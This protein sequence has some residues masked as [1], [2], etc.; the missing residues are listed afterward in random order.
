MATT[1]SQVHLEILE[2]PDNDRSVYLVKEE[3]RDLLEMQDNRVI[4][5]CKVNLV[6]R[7]K[8]VN[9]DLLVRREVMVSRECLETPEDLVGQVSTLNIVHVHNDWERQL[10]RSSNRSNTKCKLRQETK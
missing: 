6:H 8:A 4:L 10:R 9:K 2:I 7:D 5:D 1:A 3:A